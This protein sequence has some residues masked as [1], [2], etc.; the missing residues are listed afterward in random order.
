MDL[1]YLQTFENFKEID[2]PHGEDEF[3]F[4]KLSKDD[5]DKVKAFIS[6][7][8]IKCKDNNVKL[9]IENKPGIPYTDN[10]DGIMV[11][12]FFDGDTRTLACAVGKDIEYWLTILIHESSHMDQFLESDPT[13]INNIGLI[14]TDL[15][16]SGDDEVDMDVIENEIRTGIDVEVD[17]EKRSVE[18][19]KKWNLDTVINVEEYIQKSNAYILFYRW[20]HKVR[21]WYSIGKEPYNIKEIVSQMPTNFNVDYSKL[22]P[23]LEEIFK[24]YL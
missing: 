3:N 1:K 14:Q 4:G 2:N 17:C 20:M 12:G 15:W 16:L 8:K 13:W 22:T 7:L 24:K 11:N 18:K 5:I 9:R 21:S 6:D 23:R 10:E 19:I